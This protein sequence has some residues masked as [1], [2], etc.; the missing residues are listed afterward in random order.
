MRATNTHSQFAAGFISAFLLLTSA[1]LLSQ[2]AAWLRINPQPQ[3]LLD[4]L[5][6]PLFSI[7]DLFSAFVGLLLLFVLITA[8]RWAPRL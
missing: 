2:A 5:N 6:T 8:P 4:F 1:V 3:T 7:L